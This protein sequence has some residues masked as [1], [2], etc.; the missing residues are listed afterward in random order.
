MKTIMYK[1]PGVTADPNQA[2]FAVTVQ[3]PYTEAN[4]AAAKA[5]ALPGSL[6]ILEEAEAP[7][8]PMDRVLLKDR[9]TGKTFEVYVESGKLMMEVI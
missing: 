5:E 9:A 2:A 6:Q 8:E 1:K 3:L 4:L 7:A